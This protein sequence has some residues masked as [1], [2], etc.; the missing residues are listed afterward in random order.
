M[1]IFRLTAIL[2]LAS[3][4]SSSPAFAADKTL[5]AGIAA[6]DVTPQQFPISVNGGMRDVEAER[7]A[8]PLHARCLV[9]DDGQAR[10]AIVVCDSCMIPRE[11]LDE[12]KKKASQATG[13]PTD[14]MLISATHCHS[15]PTLSGVFQ[16]E[17]NQRYIAV[18]TEMIASGIKQASDNLVPAR[19]GWGTASVPDQVFNRRWLVKAG[20]V[21]TDPFGGTTDRVKMNPGYSANNDKPSGPTDPEVCFVSVQTKDGKPLAFLA[22]YSLHYVG[23]VPP[24][25]VS[26]DYFS[27]FAKQMAS[28]LGVED[29]KGFLGVMSNGTSGNINNVDYSQAS[30][31]RRQPLEKIRIVA[32]AVADACYKSYQ[33]VEHRDF[34]PIRM[35]EAEVELGVRLPGDEDVARAKKL[36]E[37][38]GPGPYTKIEHIYARETLW[39]AQYPKTVKAKLQAIRLGELGIA[40]SPCETFVETGLALKKESPLKPTFT[41]EL[42]NGYSG[43]LPTSEHHALGGYETWRAR[44]SYLS[45]DAEPKVRSTLLALLREVAAE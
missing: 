3:F 38:A 22:N 15:A 7:A 36:L 33:T 5:R 40:S 23:G 42:A 9:L 45:A 1:S 14:R 26:G 4:V 44:S 31:P 16:S 37:E 43:Y 10:I 20:V 18:L 8:D 32:S 17:P 12:A 6:V 24:L 28:R 11:L 21:L 30:P 39:M 13:I 34:V 19:I 35:R 27:E 2:V 41:I 29:T 25:S